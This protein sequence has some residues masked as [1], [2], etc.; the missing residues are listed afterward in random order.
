MRAF[1]ESCTHDFFNRKGGIRMKAIWIIIKLL[2]IG[3]FVVAY[4]DAGASSSKMSAETELMDSR[5]K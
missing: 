4:Q 2:A 5:A 3:A 1:S